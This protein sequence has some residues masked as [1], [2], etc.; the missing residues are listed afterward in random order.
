[1]RELRKGRTRLTL[2]VDLAI[3]VDVSLADH[4]VDLGVRELLACD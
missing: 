2:V 1:M 3:A 4:L